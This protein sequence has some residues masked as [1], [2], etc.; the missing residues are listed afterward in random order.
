M[1]QQPQQPPRHPQMAQQYRPQEQ[2][3]GVDDQD[4]EG[5]QDYGAN[6]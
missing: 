5:E 3:G 6:G 1:Y 2:Q 4:A